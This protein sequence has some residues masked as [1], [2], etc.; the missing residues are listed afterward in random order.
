MKLPAA[1]SFEGS[2][3]G[4][5]RP[6]ELEDALELMERLNVAMLRFSEEGRCLWSN[7][8]C[9]E[10]LGFGDREL[11]GLELGDLLAPEELVR[12]RG[13]IEDVRA[14]RARELGME[15]RLTRG[16]GTG[17][18]ARLS[19]HGLAR[20]RKING[21]AALIE[22]VLTTERRDGAFLHLVFNSLPSCVCYLDRDLRY[23][24]VNLAY[25]RWTGLRSEEI[26]G[27][28]FEEMFGVATMR[29]VRPYFD[30]V[31][32]GEVVQYEQV[33]NYLR[34][35]AR[36]VSVMYVPDMSSG[37]AAP[38]GFVVL[39]Q[40]LSEIKEKERLIS[41]QREKMVSSAKLAALGE[42]A[43]GISH[44][45]NNPLAIIHAKSVQIR[46]FARSGMMDPERVA[47][48]AEK[49][50]QM[51]LRISK[52]IKALRNIAREGQR[53][54][55]QRVNVSVLLEETSELCKERFRDYGIEFSVENAATNATIECR[56]VQISQV[57]LN[58]LNNAFDA[59]VELPERW[60]RLVARDL[61]EELLLSVVDSGPGVPREWRDRI[62]LPFV[63]TKE[64]GKG[65][66]LGLSVSKGIV[67]AHSGALLLDPESDRTCFV[68]RLP[69]SQ[70]R[71]A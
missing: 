62:F 65:M 2:S 66:G 35:G 25:E 40:D 47:S 26:L 60:V 56:S 32:S 22:P 30:R 37:G 8:A 61:G 11:A 18:R 53:D 63:T 55:F 52:I 3:T 15:L 64:V 49:I 41:E 21:F 54:P 7:P 27:R 29:I 46:N 10:L 20:D 67:E 57:L 13:A 23:R 19:L 6:F 28:T 69:R 44:E 14:G 1:A 39:I 33:L 58:L 71:P 34:V 70:R 38:Q 5:S 36:E 4:G 24:F 50:E 16:D 59:V 31:L 42:M 45:I 17:L 68:V 51:S 12:H 9:R 48:T 43:G